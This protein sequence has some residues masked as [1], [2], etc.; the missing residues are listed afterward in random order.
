MQEPTSETKLSHPIKTSSW[1]GAVQGSLV[2]WGRFYKNKFVF[3]QNVPKIPCF[4]KKIP[5]PN[6]TWMYAVRDTGRLTKCQRHLYYRGISSSQVPGHIHSKVAYGMA[7]WIIVSLHPSSGRKSGVRWS[8]DLRATFWLIGRILVLVWRGRHMASP[9]PWFS[10]WEWMGM[11]FYCMYCGLGGC[12]RELGGCTW[13]LR[14]N[15]DTRV[16][17]D[18]LDTLKDI[19]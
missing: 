2:Q 11:L 16:R 18:G 13:V 12:G 7:D 15:W 1:E 14:E 5:N 4:Y 3:P 9:R 17:A 10:V 19:P 6:S 8:V